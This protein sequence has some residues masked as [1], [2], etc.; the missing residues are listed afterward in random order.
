MRTSEIYSP[1][2]TLEFLDDGRRV[3]AIGA[4]LAILDEGGEST[5]IAT[6]DQV[7]VR[8]NDS[9]VDDRG[10]LWTATMRTADAQEPCQLYR[11]LA[12]GTL[13][14]THIPVGAGNGIAWSPDATVMYFTDSSSGTVSRAAY[15]LDSGSA[16][17]VEVFLAFGKGIPDGLTVDTAGGLWVSLWG[18]ARVNR[19]AP[20]G[21]LTDTVSLPSPF[22][23]ATAFGG[24]D[25]AE[26]FITTARQGLDDDNSGDIF[27]VDTGYRGRSRPAVAWQDTQ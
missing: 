11:L 27:I 25:F 3:V 21:T 9:G 22:V 24:D 13:S 17:S 10:R 16:T 7:D 2:G 19:F 6:L 26:L 1:L 14:A 23:T 8:F 18:D 4:Q 15:D 5:L 12:D 20:D